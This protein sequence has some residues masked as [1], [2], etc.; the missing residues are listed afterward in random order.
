MIVVTVDADAGL[1]FRNGF[2]INLETII[3][4]LGFYAEFSFR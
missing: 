4:F 2:P 3:K 1:Q